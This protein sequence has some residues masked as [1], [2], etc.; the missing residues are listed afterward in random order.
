MIEISFK[1]KQF[2]SKYPCKLFNILFSLMNY[3]VEMVSIECYIL[4]DAEN[5]S[6]RKEVC[7]NFITILVLSP[8]IIG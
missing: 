5:I 6:S 3:Y 2:L 8:Y 1:W 4:T 7:L